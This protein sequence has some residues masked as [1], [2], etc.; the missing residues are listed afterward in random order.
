MKVDRE[1]I[2]YY[3]DEVFVFAILVLS[4]I[5]SSAIILMIRNGDISK[6]DFHISWV[7][8]IACS[9][10][11][12]LVTGSMNESFVY[13]EGKKK[14]PLMKRIYINVLHGIAWKSVGDV[15]S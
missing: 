10:I 2:I 7:K 14:P 8:A 6:G 12:I 4:I 1:K 5:F 15:I 13:R 9:L 3:A 11:A